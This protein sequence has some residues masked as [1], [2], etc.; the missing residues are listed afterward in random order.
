MLTTGNPR[1]VKRDFRALE[2]RRFAALKLL[3]QGYNQSEVARRLP[4]CSQ[5]VSR[6]PRAVSADGEQALEAAGRAVRKPLRDG[7]RSG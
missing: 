3:Q 5:T 4:V 7:K 6:W 2:Q 1:G